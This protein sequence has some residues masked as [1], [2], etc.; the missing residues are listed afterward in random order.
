MVGPREP[1]RTRLDAARLSDGRVSPL[2]Q[3]S[4]DVYKC[5]FADGSWFCV[6]PSGTEPKV[7]IYISAS[8]PHSYEAASAKARRILDGVLAV[9]K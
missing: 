9:I 3:I 5:Y 6:R 7:K 4:S 8:D 1:I 2:P